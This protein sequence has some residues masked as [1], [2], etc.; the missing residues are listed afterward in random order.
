MIVQ[1]KAKLFF[2]FVIKVEIHLLWVIP[3]KEIKNS[4]LSK[5]RVFKI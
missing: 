1:N 2:Q 4:V 3:I 5:R